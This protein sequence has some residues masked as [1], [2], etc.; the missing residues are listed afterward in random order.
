[1]LLRNGDEFSADKL[2]THEIIS[3]RG[4]FLKEAR[5]LKAILNFTPGPQV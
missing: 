5:G 4:Q 3:H 2:T 1:L